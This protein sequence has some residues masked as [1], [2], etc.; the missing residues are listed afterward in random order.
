MAARHLVGGVLC[1]LGALLA[2]S[3]FGAMGA[4]QGGWEG[5]IAL[6]LLLAAALLLAAGVVAFA[7]GRLGRARR[8]LA[9]AGAGYLFAAVAFLVAEVARGRFGWSDAAN[10]PWMA[11]FLVLLPLFA[12]KSGDLVVV[13]AFV[14]GA[15][16]AFVATRGDAPYAPPPS[17]P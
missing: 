8:A 5:L 13:L 3:A 9:C 4:N 14:A 12:L 17:R 15:A 10:L 6:V 16:V 11:A 7:W 1:A 2:V